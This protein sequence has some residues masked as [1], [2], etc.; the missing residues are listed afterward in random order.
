ME[1][2]IN[3]QFPLLG[4]GRISRSANSFYLRSFSHTDNTS[5]LSILG[6]IEQSKNFCKFSSPMEECSGGK[7]PIAASQKVNKHIVY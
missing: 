5:F 1:I 4:A 3:Q 6:N 2:S 7:L